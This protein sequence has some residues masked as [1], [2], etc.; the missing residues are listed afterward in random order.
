[1]SRPPNPITAIQYALREV[2]VAVKDRTIIPRCLTPVLKDCPVSKCSQTRKTTIP[3]AAA[4]P[5]VCVKNE[6][7]PKSAPAAPTL[8]GLL[9]FIRTL[10]A[11]TTAN[12]LNQWW[13]A[14]GIFPK[15]RT[16]KSAA[17][18]TAADRR[19]NNNE[20][21]KHNQ[22]KMAPKTRT[23]Q[24]TTASRVPN[25]LNKCRRQDLSQAGKLKEIAVDAR[26]R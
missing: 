10:I 24:F 3:A 13:V 20:R 19:I 22:H 15:R 26:D 23:T 17:V 25:I 4:A 6:A 7:R 21:R 11:R 1:V 12:T 18:A 5:L 9:V 14:F 16:T 2:Q 8:A